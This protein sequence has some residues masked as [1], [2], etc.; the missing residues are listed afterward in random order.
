MREDYSVYYNGD[1]IA[2]Y[3]RDEKINEYSYY[4]G[5]ANYYKGKV[6]DKYLRTF[7]NR[8]KPAPFL[9]AIMKD[10]NRVSGTRKLIYEKDKV[11]I[12]RRPRDVDRFMV[13]NMH[14]GNN[15]EKHSAPHYEGGKIIDDMK[16]WASY[17]QFVKMDDNTFEVEL[18]ENWWWGGGHNDGGTI[19]QEIPEEYFDL[20]YDEFLEK[21]V[22]VGKAEHYGFDAHYLR[23]KE[24]LREF[25]GF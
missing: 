8:D 18:E 14:G 9:E 3:Y 25:F 4:V 20:P 12:V 16:E 10:E 2:S 7:E 22:T 21:V 13:Y 19:H 15:D 6:P 11:R 5:N 24:G 17:Y 1:C 23:K